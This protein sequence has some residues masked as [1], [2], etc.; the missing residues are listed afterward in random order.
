MLPMYYS[1][2][3]LFRLGAYKINDIFCMTLSRAQFHRSI[4]LLWVWLFFNFV[5]LSVEEDIYLTEARDVL[6]VLHGR[7]CPPRPVVVVCNLRGHA[8]RM[9]LIL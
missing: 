4:E 5:A 8:P 9:V 3:Y 2:L 7:S 1:N 6:K